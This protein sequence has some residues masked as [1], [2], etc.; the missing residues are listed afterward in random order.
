MIVQD[1]SG[2]DSTVKY[3]TGQ[4]RTVLSATV[5]I[6][7]CSNMWTLAHLKCTSN[8]LYYLLKC[9]CS[10]DTFGGAGQAVSQHHT[11]APLAWAQ[12]PHGEGASESMCTAVVTAAVLHRML[13]S[14]TQPG[15]ANFN[16]TQHLLETWLNTH[17]HTH[18]C[19]GTHTCTLAYPLLN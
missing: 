14:S 7:I 13:N 1:S 10:Q 2:H 15:S 11:Q 18:T 16:Q 12:S 6:S 4:Y 19:T 3:S 9:K 17:T 5:R 8:S